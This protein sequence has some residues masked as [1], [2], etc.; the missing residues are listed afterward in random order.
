MAFARGGLVLVRVPLEIGHFASGKGGLPALATYPRA[1]ALPENRDAALQNLQ[2]NMLAQTIKGPM[3]S[4]VRTWVT[5][6]NDWGVPPWPV[7]ADAL[8]KVGASMRQAGYSS[9]KLY[10]QAAMHH[11]ET[12]LQQAVPDLLKKLARGSTELR[13]AP[14][15][16]T[17][18]DRL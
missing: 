15:R 14:S 1:A 6:C 13:P 4:W 3:E 2:A 16:A 9:V 18:Q 7:C 10:F 11:Q 17:A 8:R 12:A 5:I